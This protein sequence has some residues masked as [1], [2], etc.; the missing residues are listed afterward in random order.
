MDNHT[1]K[2]DVNIARIVHLSWAAQ[3]EY[4]AR[5]GSQNQ[6]M[7]SK[8]NCELGQW[9]RHCDQKSAG[10]NQ[11]VRELIPIHAKFHES[12]EAV[13]GGL[14]HEEKPVHDADIAAIH[15][16]SHDIIY[17]L[18]KIEL[19]HVGKE[20]PPR[21]E[22]NHPVRN[23]FLRLLAGDHGVPNEKREVL[24]IN[25]SRLV[26]LQWAENLP[27]SFRHRGHNTTLESSESCALGVW[28]QETGLT[29]FAGMEEMALLHSV[30]N[31][32]HEQTG[33]TISALKQR[34]DR[35]AETAYSKVLEYSR[36]I[37]HL[38]SLIEFKLIGDS[39][40][41]RGSSVIE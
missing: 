22:D 3:F 29:K 32:F 5:G 36:E 37:I 31:N 28:I 9:L 2:L 14:A 24:E 1:L 18:T 21:M 4:I 20:P 41:Y 6:Y 39:A 40:I 35:T 15:Q 13:L 38:L 33:I 16:L 19:S 10:E 25:Y 7:P 11:L 8:F 26:H 23:L 27:N 30:H 34:R 12:C 17:L